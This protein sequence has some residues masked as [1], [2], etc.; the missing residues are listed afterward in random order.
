MTN[1]T[2]PSLADLVSACRKDESSLYDFL[3][4]VHAGQINDVRRRFLRRGRAARARVIQLHDRQNLSLGEHWLSL[5]EPAYF[6][7][8]ALHVLPGSFVLVRDDDPSSVIAY[9]LS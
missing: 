1:P 9:T 2:S 4:T 5:E 7:D 3:E 8:E 6:T